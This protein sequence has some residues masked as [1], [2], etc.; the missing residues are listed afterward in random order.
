MNTSL[1][2]LDAEI[3]VSY[4]TVYQRVQRSQETLDAPQPHFRFPVEI[5]K[6]YMRA[7]LKGRELDQHVRAACPRVGVEHTLR[8][9]SLCLFSQIA[10]V[11]NGCV[12]S[13]YGSEVGH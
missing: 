8:T 6:S 1:K 7:G 3:D 4:K 5:D 11:V 9:S 10:V 13:L 12:E 2:Q